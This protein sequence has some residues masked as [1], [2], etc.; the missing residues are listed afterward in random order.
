MSARDVCVRDG[1]ARMYVPFGRE[2]CGLAIVTP[3]VQRHLH[4]MHFR[5]RTA[6]TR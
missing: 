5:V 4:R 6:F 2:V 1:R 3:G